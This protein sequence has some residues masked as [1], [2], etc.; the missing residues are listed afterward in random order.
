MNTSVRSILMFP[1]NFFPDYCN[2]KD[3]GNN[4]GIPANLNSRPGTS[5]AK[6]WP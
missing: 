5:F 3:P 6:Q 1:S 2:G 4:N